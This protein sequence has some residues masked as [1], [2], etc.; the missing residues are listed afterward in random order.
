M[1]LRSHTTFRAA[2]PMCPASPRSRMPACG[3]VS[4]RASRTSTVAV[5][6]TASPQ[7]RQASPKKPRSITTNALVI[8][9]MMDSVVM[10]SRHMVRTSQPSS[11]TPLASTVP[12][13]TNDSATA[14]S[15]EPAHVQSVSTS[16]NHTHALER[17]TVRAA[18]E[19]RACA[20]GAAVCCGMSFAQT[21]NYLAATKTA[22]GVIRLK[23][24][25]EFNLLR[26]VASGL[27]SRASACNRTLSLQLLCNA[28]HHVTGFGL[29]VLQCPC[30]SI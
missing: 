15:L 28:A 16:Q 20:A 2:Q 23:S 11:P 26:T 21:V 27:V 17:P 6:A 9:P 5:Q 29:L 1:A 30:R 22:P 8:A 18:G 24:L 14:P 12:P 10:P 4:P 3:Q 19:V 25:M 13:T 7:S